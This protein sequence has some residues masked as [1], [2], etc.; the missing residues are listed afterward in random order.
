MI[1]RDVPP[2]GISDP[3]NRHR[4]LVIEVA[5]VRHG[6]GQMRRTALSTI[7]RVSRGRDWLSFFNH[8]PDA[9]HTHLTLRD[10][11]NAARQVGHKQ[12]RPS[13]SKRGCLSP[14]R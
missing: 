5:V 3:P 11:Y 12:A 8:S 1:I 4:R 14:R 9:L 2:L 7:G 6:T 10:T 13:S